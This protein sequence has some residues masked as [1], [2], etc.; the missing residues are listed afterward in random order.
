MIV[1]KH[2]TNLIFEKWPIRN[3]GRSKVRLINFAAITG[4]LLYGRQS[5]K[6]Q[7]NFEQALLFTTSSL[8]LRSTAS[9]PAWCGLLSAHR[10]P[11]STRAENHT[12]SEYSFLTWLLREWA[13]PPIDLAALVPPTGKNLPASRRNAYTGL[14]KESCDKTQ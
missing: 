9:S 6:S 13:V 1:A 12:A 7:V 2:V 3:L 10:W 8:P 5:K 11:A 14:H 4:R